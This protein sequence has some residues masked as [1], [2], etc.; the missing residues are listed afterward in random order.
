MSFT[1]FIINKKTYF[2]KMKF[3]Q[4]LI[5]FILFSNLNSFSNNRIEKKVIKEIHL[6]FNIQKYNK[7]EILLK[8]NDLLNVKSMFNRGNFFKIFNKENHIGYYYKSIAKS[9]TDYFDYLILFDLDLNILNSKVLAYRE[10]YGGEIASKRW[11]RQF[12]G[13]NIND[14]LK[15]KENVMAISG[16]TISV[17]SMTIA[18]DNLMTSL[19]FVKSKKY[20]D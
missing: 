13:K 8:S 19:K 3:L 18:I 5:F 4:Y 9:K 6:S 11:L 16:A 12:V 14:R 2:C 17:K 10:D 15:Y 20:L 1:S 7:T